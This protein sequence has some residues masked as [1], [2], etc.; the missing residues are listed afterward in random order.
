MRVEHNDV[1]LV[2]ELRML[3]R[4]HC[5]WCLLGGQHPPYSLCLRNSS[6]RWAA[7]AAPAGRT[8]DPPA[9]LG[10]PDRAAASRRMP[11]QGFFGEDGD[12]IADAEEHLTFAIHDKVYRIRVAN[13]LALREKSF[14]FMQR[15]YAE[16]AWGTPHPSGMLFSS[17][18][19][20]PD[21]VTLL[22]T[23]A[24]KV[25]ATITVV[26][27]SPLG[28]PDDATYKDELD[29]RRAKGRKLA[30]II[31]LGVDADVRGS[32]ELL[33]RLFNCAYFVARGIKGATDFVITVLPHHTMFYKRKMLFTTVGD[34]RLQKKTG[35][36]VRLLNLDFDDAEREA[37]REHGSA[38]PHRLGCRTIYRCFNAVQEAPG[39]VAHFR[40]KVR[41]IDLESL[42]YFLARKPELMLKAS[43][44][45]KDYVRTYVT[46]LAR[47]RS[48]LKQLFGIA[49]QGGAAC[50]CTGDG[51]T[52]D[53]REA[54]HL[55]RWQNAVRPAC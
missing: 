38:R 10:E 1:D 35:V 46:H 47:H 44:T 40:G 31:S 55:L 51:L 32:S 23:H 52:A 27:D 2:D 21:T 30:Q 49:D 3:Q 45:E 22:V 20:L 50:V 13:D 18:E 15:I 42:S 54:F 11:D 26:V 39:M 33:V 37:L 34:D 9:T 6:P 5:I 14:R 7:D 19:L 4:G 12:S 53:G 41:P 24:D 8:E 25:M 43:D 16:K 48:W 29:R 28:L 36:V 17:Y